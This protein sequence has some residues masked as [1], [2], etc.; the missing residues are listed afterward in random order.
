MKARDFREA[1]QV[2]ARAKEDF[3]SNLHDL[4]VRGQRLIQESVASGVTCMRAHVEVDTIV[5]RAC[6]DIALLLKREWEG[7]CD[8]QISS[9]YQAAASTSSRRRPKKYIYCSIRPG[10]PLSISRLCLSRLEL[11]SSRRS[12]AD[13]RRG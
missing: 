10:T 3:V 1:L 13:P 8:V 6:L 9:M 4:H 11:H 12:R 7:K 2:T 5:G